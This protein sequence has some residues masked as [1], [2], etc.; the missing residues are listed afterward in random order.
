[1]DKQL[2]SP[3][4]SGGVRSPAPNSAQNKNVGRALTSWPSDLFR[5]GG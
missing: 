4:E 5:G 2:W 1:M 3:I